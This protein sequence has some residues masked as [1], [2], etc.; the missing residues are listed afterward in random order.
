M[1]T[2]FKEFYRYSDVDIKKIWNEC[3]FVFDTNVLLDLYRYSKET[4][5]KYIGVLKKIKIEKRI[6]IPHQV[7]LEFHKRRIILISDL[8]NSY[9]EI[10]KI[11]EDSI[12][13]AQK[14]IDDKYHKEHPFLDFKNIYTELDGCLKKIIGI[15]DENEKAHPDWFNKDTILDELDDLLKGNIGD[16]YSQ[17]R[18]IEIYKEGKERYSNNIPPGYE[19]ATDKDNERKYGDLILWYQIIDKAK[20]SK[21]PIIFITRD[22]KED[23]WWKQSGNTIGPRHELKKEIL[24]KAKV[25]FHMYDSERFLEY[26]FEHYK[27]VVDKE[28]LKEIKRVKAF[29]ERNYIVHK[30]SLSRELKES[31]VKE[32]I[33]QQEML[34]AELSHFSRQFDLDEEILFE[35]NKN[36]E[37]IVHFLGRFAHEDMPHPIMFEELFM[38]QERMQRRIIDL[39]ETK[40]INKEQLRFV[41]RFIERM[42]D[43]FLTLA[44]Y[45]DKDGISKEY[46]RRMEMNNHRL[47]RYFMGF[48]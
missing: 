43:A 38:L 47:H 26:A 12:A 30:M 25:E 40:K 7:G 48:E 29:D 16:N 4:S 19:D 45:F 42:N 9:S 8:K 20:D 46:Y 28:A 18:L 39:I 22:K 14:K 34:N 31:F 5:D 24:T 37:R 23:W 41:I 13:D 33:M 17:E 1:K 2:K 27:Q 32:V 36:K 35:F 3:I 11:L 6:W 10:K 21:K 15:I 44:K